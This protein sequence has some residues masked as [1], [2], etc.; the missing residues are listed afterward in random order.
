MGNF[1]PC[2]CNYQIRISIWTLLK[3]V[4]VN[5]FLLQSSLI[6]PQT[7][8]WT[9]DLIFILVPSLH[10]FQFPAQAWMV[11]GWGPDNLSSSFYLFLNFCILLL[12]P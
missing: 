10:A 2:Y 1:P 9:G 4:I 5:G 3:E 8:S 6:S 11:F 7:C 12:F